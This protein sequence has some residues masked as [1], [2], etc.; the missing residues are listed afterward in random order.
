VFDGVRSA[1]LRVSGVL[2]TFDPEMDARRTEGE[3]KSGYFT[4]VVN[5]TS[6]DWLEADT[7]ALEVMEMFSILICVGLL[8]FAVLLTT[9]SELRES[10]FAK[11]D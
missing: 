1:A 10:H 4:E 3:V 2:I 5:N 7:D 9:K 6:F 8:S 11:S